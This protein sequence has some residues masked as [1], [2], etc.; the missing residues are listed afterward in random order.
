MF[1]NT[2]ILT[3][4]EQ[5]EIMA[6]VTKG[7]D[8]RIKKTN[9]L[10]DELT[11]IYQQI[12]DNGGT[13]TRNQQKRI[14]QIYEEMKEQAV[15]SMTENEAEQNMILNRLGDNNEQITAEM[16]GNTIKQMN[17]LRDKSIQSAAEKRDALVLEAEKLKTVENGKYKDK[18]D[19]II[20]EANREYEGAVDA[21]EKL[22]TEGIDKVM[23]AH[24]DMADKISV[25][26]GE[27]L[28]WWERL[29]GQYEK[30]DPKP[31]NVTINF[32]T[33]GL[34]MLKAANTIA[35]KFHYNGLDYVPFDGYNARLHEGERVL[36]KKENEA[37]TQAKQNGSGIGRKLIVEVP[38][39]IND[40][41]FAHATK[42]AYMEEL[43][44]AMEG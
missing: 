36:T 2:T 5:Q 14:D 33:F 29:T 34:D 25:N 1:A 8:D 9:E 16:V 27:V 28:T 26:T 38:L 31:K 10:R 20:K 3:A 41:E 35:S 12:A 6:S 22:R 39:K 4:Q 18:A 11:G 43:G 37:Y 17:E 30:W 13:I 40:R 32:K 19:A 7:Y 44:F 42:E 23:Y 24:Q 21:A 15:Q